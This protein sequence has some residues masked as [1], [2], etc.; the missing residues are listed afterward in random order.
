ML[1]AVDTTFGL[2]QNLQIIRRSFSDFL[3]MERQTLK[4]FLYLFRGV[5]FQAL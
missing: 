5:M 4:I 2:Y 3:V 1:Y